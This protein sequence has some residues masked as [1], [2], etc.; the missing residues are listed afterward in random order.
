MFFGG[1]GGHGD[2]PSTNPA[3][4]LQDLANPARKPNS[5]HSLWAPWVPLNKTCE[6]TYKMCSYGFVGF[7]N[8][9][10]CHLVAV[11]VIWSLCLS[12][13]RCACHLV[14]VLVIWLLCLS[15]GRC[16]CSFMKKYF[17]QIFY[18]IFNNFII[19]VYFN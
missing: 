4:K 2:A 8:S 11:L 12:S 3:R 7:L 14:A 1:T 5:K 9:C 18:F 16:A 6:H 13:G 15:S 10:A 19:F 17:F